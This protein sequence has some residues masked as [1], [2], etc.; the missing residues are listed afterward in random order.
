MANSCKNACLNTRGNA[1]R[2]TCR[3]GNINA[4]TNACMNASMNLNYKVIIPTV[5]FHSL[6]KESI[7]HPR[8]TYNSLN[9][10]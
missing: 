6:A 1:Y 8:Y 3:N 9:K 5:Q 10:S 2:N 7:K 4:R